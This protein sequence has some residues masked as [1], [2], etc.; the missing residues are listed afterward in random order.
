[1]RDMSWGQSALARVVGEGVCGSVLSTE[2]SWFIINVCSA[3]SLR[4]YIPRR[5]VVQ[6]A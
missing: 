6:T 1:M 2:F 4:Q 3:V 5:H